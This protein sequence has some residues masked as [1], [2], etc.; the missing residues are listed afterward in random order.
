MDFLVVFIGSPTYVKNPYLRAKFVEVLRHWMPNTDPEGGRDTAVQ[1]YTRGLFEAHAL[2]ERHL[3][4][5]LLSLY[6]DVEFTGANT[7]FYDK[8][9]IRYSLGNLLEYLWSVPGHRAVWCALAR[10]GDTF[11]LRFTN[12]I[13][14]DAIYQLDEALKKIPGAAGEISGGHPLRHLLTRILGFAVMGGAREQVLSLGPLSRMS[15]NPA[16]SS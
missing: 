11:Y 2:S 9:N 3:T 15:W 12:M 6:V 14:N 8:M 5:A 7:Q 10:R 16:T 1:M 4:H 13:V